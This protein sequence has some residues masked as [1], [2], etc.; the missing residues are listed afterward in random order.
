VAAYAGTCLI[1]SSTWIAIKV[2]LRGAPPLTGIAVRMAIASMIVLAILRARRIPLPRER[3]FVR[4]GVF[5]G[6]FHVVLPYSLVY[7][8]EQRIPSGLAAVLYATM[9]LFVAL[10][11][12]ATL[13]DPLTPHK[14]IGIT[15]GIAGVAVIFMDSLRIGPAEATGT[16]YVLGSVLAS[17]VGS[18]ATKRWSQA[19]HPVASLQIPF[20]TGAVVTTIAAV[21]FERVNPLH[22]DAPTWVSIL[23]LAGAG[24]VAAFSLFFY[25]MKRLDVTVVSYQTFI[26]PVLAVLLGWVFLGEHISRQVALGALCIVAGVSIATVFAPRT[27]GRVVLP[28]PQ[29]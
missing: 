14:L 23:Y 25:V 15:A 20:V 16:L 27:R 6:F 10:L 28:R 5:L 19:Y 17:T 3:R 24:S 9:P 11:A 12:R 29:A 13:G 21:A 26:I 22:F 7:L 8:G 2:G 1:W 4:L 18:V